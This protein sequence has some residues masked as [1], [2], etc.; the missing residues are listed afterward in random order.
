MTTPGTLVRL[1]EPP[2]PRPG[3][4]GW[5]LSGAENI[6]HM[7]RL[8]PFA[9]LQKLPPE[10]THMRFEGS[11]LR[12]T[13]LLVCERSRRAL[14]PE[15]EGP[16]TAGRRTASQ[17]RRKQRRSLR[18][19][20]SPCIHRALDSASGVFSWTWPTAA[21]PLHADPSSYC[22]QPRRDRGVVEFRCL[23]VLRSAPVR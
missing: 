5:P 22:G 9:S 16:Y 11:K 20:R 18:R 10:G 2:P 8:H 12:C 15:M 19:S 7:F 23:G 4:N 1:S 13:D 17:M 3:K 21:D 14:M 6:P